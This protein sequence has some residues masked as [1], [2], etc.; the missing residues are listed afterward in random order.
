MQVIQITSMDAKQDFMTSGDLV[1][2]GLFPSA[3]AVYSARKR[4]VSPDF[5]KIGT[6]V[7]YP[8]SCVIDFV[9]KCLKS[10]KSQTTSIYFETEYDEA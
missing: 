1:D 5:V 4:G 2:L 10:G 3:S 8:K 9:K 7:L 6:K